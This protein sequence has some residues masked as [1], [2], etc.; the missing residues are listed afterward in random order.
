MGTAETDGDAAAGAAS[1]GSIDMKLEVVV[2]PVSDVDRAKEFYG[3]LGW[4][5]DADVA[6]GDAFRLVQFTPPGSGASVQFGTNLTAAA[7]GS[8]QGLYL[9]VSD[10]QAVHDLLEARGVGVGEV[11][12]E[13]ERGARFHEP[14]RVAGRAPERGSYGSF[15]AFSD[16][17]GNG[18]L[19]QEVTA[20]LPG[21]VDPAATSFGSAGELASALR[22]AAAAHG[23]AR[24]ANGRGGC[25]LAR[26]VRGLHGEGAGRRGAALVST[27]AGKAVPPAQVP[28]P[29]PSRAP[30]APG[31]SRFRPG[32]GWAAVFVLVL[33]VNLFF[34]T[35]ATAP[36]S[37]VR[38]PYSPFFVDQV[39]AGRVASITSKGRRSRGRSPGSSA[40]GARSRPSCS[41]P[42]F[43]RLPTPT[44]SR[45][46]CRLTV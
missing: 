4:R 9:V 29:A 21:R 41:A 8:A 1:A 35:Q 6:A 31:G 45:T 26:L 22:R 17:D 36:V 7:P 28:A 23:G 2:V 40:T 19:V 12:H 38:V 5:L 15:A 33:V 34:S 11:F 10:I 43:R 44:G 32:A 30:G 18:W 13:G 16:P 3:R 42:R 24:D 20:R 14:G 27:K 46:F 39:R 25:E 37:R